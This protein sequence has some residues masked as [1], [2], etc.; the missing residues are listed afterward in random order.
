MLKDPTPSNPKPSDFFFGGGEGGGGGGYD[1]K[2]R[3]EPKPRV[4]G[5]QG[6]RVSGFWGFGSWGLGFRVLEFKGFGGL[7]L[8]V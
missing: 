8:R 1:L 2:P 5:F 6:F 7:G 3:F 4:S